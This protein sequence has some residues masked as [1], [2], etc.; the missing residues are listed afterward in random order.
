MLD[1][2]KSPVEATKEAPAA[3]V[4]AG[5]LTDK[6]GAVSDEPASKSILA[7]PLEPAVRT[8]VPPESEVIT[9]LMVI[10]ELAPDVCMTKL[11]APD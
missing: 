6:L 8:V 2:C 4:R 9:L 5:V 3:T 7:V 1:S 10:S 11:P